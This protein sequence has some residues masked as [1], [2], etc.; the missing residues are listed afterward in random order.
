M[1][2]QRRKTT[3]EQPVGGREMRM[4]R[5]PKKRIEGKRWKKHN[6]TREKKLNQHAQSSKSMKIKRHRSTKVTLTNLIELLTR[7]YFYLWR[8][9][10]CKDFMIKMMQ[11][12][13]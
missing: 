7:E 8:N 1:K 4:K 12:Y 5:E 11:K 10:E 9:Y 2:G 3:R 6:K 13:K